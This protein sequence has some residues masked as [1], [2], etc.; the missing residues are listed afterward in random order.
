MIVNLNI[1]NFRCFKDFNF[2]PHNSMAVTFIGN[3]STGKTA[4]IDAL[5]V[6]QMIAK[7]VDSVP[8]AIKRSD[9]SQFAS[10]GDLIELDIKVVLNKTTFS[11]KI[12][13]E[14][15]EKKGLNVVYE[16]LNINEL[17][18][19]I[20]DQSNVSVNRDDD[21]T[22]LFMADIATSVIALARFNHIY[23]DSEISV[24]LDFLRNMI[25][26]SP[27]SIVDQPKTAF[28]YPTF[29]VDV[30]D[31]TMFL[32]QI[33][34]EHPSTYNHIAS[35]V[36]KFM[37]NF[38]IFD[39]TW[40]YQQ[41]SVITVKYKSEDSPVLSYTYHDLSDGD[42]SIFFTAVVLAA[43]TVKYRVPFIFWEN[44]LA[45][46]PSE[47]FES[48]LTQSKKVYN[49]SLWFSSNDIRILNYFT[50]VPYKLVRESEV[51]AVSFNY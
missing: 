10:P 46:L 35:F 9:L 13:L 30:Q 44:P 27:K 11:Y 37:P 12:H 7:G 47:V 28:A 41:N 34:S 15:N 22:Y 26:I 24:F 23:S 25:L 51:Q 29:Y 19:L 17:D 5:K 20:R 40:D 50:D 48:F 38:Y 4:L 18:Y 43:I 39:L 49:A 31:F 42:K 32:R 6:F 45:H 16:E 14:P 1:K 36:K 21:S 2:T 3:S 33:L 8:F